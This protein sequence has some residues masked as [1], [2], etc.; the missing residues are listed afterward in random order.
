VVDAFIHQVRHGSTTNVGDRQTHHQR[1]DQCA[2]HQYLTMLRLLRILLI[3][4]H[5]MMVHCKQTEQVV[6]TFSD[7]FAHTV[8]INRACSEIFKVAPEWNFYIWVH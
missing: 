3:Q 5:W 6:I 8:L 7:G 4:M 1:K 2:N